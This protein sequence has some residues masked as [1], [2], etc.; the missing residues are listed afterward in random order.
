MISP[1]WHYFP[2]LNSVAI[3][4]PGTLYSKANSRRLTFSGRQHKPRVI[5]SEE[6]MAWTDAAV[7]QLSQLQ[8]LDEQAHEKPLAKRFCYAVKVDVWYA[9]WSSDLDE[10]LA[11][12]ALTK[13]GVILDDNLII[14][15]GGSKWVSKTNPRTVITVDLLNVRVEERYDD[16]PKPPNPRRTKPPHPQDS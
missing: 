1:S 4:I 13:A 11:W 16:P 8:P 7:L 10:S 6:A 9:R 15:K 5:K 12:D 3:T 2:V 14:H